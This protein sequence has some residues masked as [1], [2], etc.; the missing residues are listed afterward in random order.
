MSIVGLRANVHHR[1][2]QGIGV[3]TAST[4][5]AIPQL[6]IDS[7][8]LR[9]TVKLAHLIASRAVPITDQEGL[10]TRRLHDPS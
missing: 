10:H 3:K 4:V 6:I 2:G 7:T 9:S 8:S 5:K 1:R